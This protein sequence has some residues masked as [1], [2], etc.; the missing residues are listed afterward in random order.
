MKMLVLYRYRCTAPLSLLPRS[1]LLHK[2][3]RVH[4]TTRFKQKESSCESEGVDHKT[5]IITSRQHGSSFFLARV[6]SLDRTSSATLPHAQVGIIDTLHNSMKLTT[7]PCLENDAMGRLA[8]VLLER[9]VCRLTSPLGVSTP[10][11]L[12]SPFLPELCKRDDLPVLKAALRAVAN[13]RCA[14]IMYCSSFLHRCSSAL[15][16]GPQFPPP[17]LSALPPRARCR[18]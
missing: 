11:N 1:T 15:T 6:F 12:M 5:T 9:V 7:M 13:L 10:S 16:E 2:R 18:P 14:T 3:T 8:G 17:P 4:D